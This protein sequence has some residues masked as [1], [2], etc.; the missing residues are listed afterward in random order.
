MNG[1]I[2]AASTEPRAALRPLK[3]PLYDTAHMPDT[4]AVN[5]L[6]F[7]Q[8]GQG[9]PIVAAGAAKPEADTNLK[10]QGQ[11]AKPLEFLLYAL[12]MEIIADGD[13]GVE[14]ITNFHAIFDRSSVE[15]FFGQQH[16]W[17]STSSIL[18]G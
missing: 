16:P 2:A 10:Q 1:R 9:S 14:N 12:N 15:F 13:E 8:S 6:N 7:F 18:P 4:V 11:I 5:R 3:Q 17:L